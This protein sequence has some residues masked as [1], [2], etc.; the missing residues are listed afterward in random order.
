MDAKRR[1]YERVFTEHGKD[2]FNYALRRIRVLYIFDEM[3]RDE[4]ESFELK[5]RIDPQLASEVR[6]IA[7]THLQMSGAI[8]AVAKQDFTGSLQK[9]FK[10]RSL[11]IRRMN[12]V[13][14]GMAS[15]G[16]VLLMFTNNL[17]QN[18]MEKKADIASV[19]IGLVQQAIL[20][21][22][23][24]CGSYPE[25]LVALVEKPEGVENWKGPYLEMD[26][27]KDPWGTLYRLAVE[28]DKKFIVSAG[29]DDEFATDD[30]IK[31]EY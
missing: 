2:L 30:D 27:L 29:E 26:K 19:S 24:H 31:R 12:G 3:Y 9:I 21:Y 18:S 28:G 16:L 11:W 13:L 7:E 6:A 5:L 14:I 8:K 23:L 10:P 17:S 20:L 1:W 22:R 15:V 25:T 4:R